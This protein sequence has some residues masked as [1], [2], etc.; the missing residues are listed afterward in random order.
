MSMGMFIGIVE[1]PA[2]T[3]APRFGQFAEFA[4]FADHRPAM[5]RHGG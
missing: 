2:S 1:C 3:S 5:S 4:E